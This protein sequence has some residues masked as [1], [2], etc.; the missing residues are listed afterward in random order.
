MPRNLDHRIE[1]L[2]PV[3]RARSRQELLAVL[4]S[5]F[6]DNTNAWELGAD[7]RWTRLSRARAS[8]PHAHQTWLARR[9]GERARRRRAEQRER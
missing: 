8:R 7:G 4:D 9:A 5:V 3:E 6:A 1:V 2:M